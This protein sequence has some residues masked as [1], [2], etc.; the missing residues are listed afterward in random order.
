[1]AK[2]AAEIIADF[3]GMDLAEMKDYRYHYGHTS[4]PVYAIGQDYFCSPPT[5][6]KPPKSFGEWKKEAT[7]AF[8]RI[9]YK[10]TGESEAA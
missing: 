3:L 6:S 1:M 5:N 2:Q 7:L 8:D 10:A 4:V 9:I